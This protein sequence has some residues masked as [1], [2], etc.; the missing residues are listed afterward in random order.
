MAYTP[1]LVGLP[2][3]MV[4]KNFLDATIWTEVSSSL[5]RIFNSKIPDRIYAVNLNEGT[6]IFVFY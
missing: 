6:K 1:Y 2:A 5:E 4:T 3:K